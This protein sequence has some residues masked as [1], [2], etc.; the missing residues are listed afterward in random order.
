M[1]KIDLNSGIFLRIEGELGKNNSLSVDSLIKISK[2]LQAL[3]F[4]I[5]KHEISNQE[6][7]NLENFKIDL[8][9]FKTGSAV[10]QFAF[11]KEFSETIGSGV[12]N[13]RNQV[14]EKLLSHLKLVEK[15]KTEELANQLNSTVAR[16]EIIDKMYLFTNSFG[17]SP[18]SFVRFEE[19]IPRPLLKINRIKKETRDQL[20]T[21][22][23]E[24]NMVMEETIKYAKVS[25][26][27]DKHGKEL[28]RPSVRELYD[29]KNNSID[30]SP[31]IIPTEN[32]NYILAFP[33]RS[34]IENK[35]DFVLIE[36]EWL[37]IISSGEN[38]EE[39]EKDFFDSFD[40]LYRRLI[41]LDEEQ[42][43]KKFKLIKLNIINLVKEIE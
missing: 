10:P 33:L 11:S 15:G 32:R 6:T 17:S 3:V 31:E 40:Y 37:D 24:A 7:V 26:K 20:I 9:G 25:Y 22:V 12:N 28:K 41:E 1:E 16:N 29:S 38:M 34:K 43:S 18:A 42:L 13:Q 21:K 36:C 8:T 19:E 27:I 5:A 2:E 4:A 23:L 35:D 14:N 30:Y 39:A